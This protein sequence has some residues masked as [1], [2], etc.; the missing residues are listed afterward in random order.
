MD[1]SL[2]E[3][4]AVQVVTSKVLNSNCNIVLYLTLYVDVYHW[5][6]RQFPVHGYTTTLVRWNV[7]IYAARTSIEIYWSQLKGV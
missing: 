1:S 6:N 7:H 5:M 3:C 4:G 2:C